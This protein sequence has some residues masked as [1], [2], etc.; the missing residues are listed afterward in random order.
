M[1]EDLAG[2][3]GPPPAAP[4]WP[5]IDRTSVVGGETAEI[6]LD[7]SKRRSTHGDIVCLHEYRQKLSD[8]GSPS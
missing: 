5:E 1:V 3:H 6:L 4:H 2:R 7:D 8:F